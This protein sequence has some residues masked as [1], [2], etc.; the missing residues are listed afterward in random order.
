MFKL[1]KIIAALMSTVGIFLIF[2]A[3]GGSDCGTLSLGYSILLC[4]VGLVLTVLGFC[5]NIIV[6]YAKEEYHV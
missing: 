1:F 5:I 2:G 6:E 3:I 4:I